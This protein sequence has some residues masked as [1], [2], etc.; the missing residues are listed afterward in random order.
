MR[1]IKKIDLLRIFLRSFYIQASWNYPRLISLGFCYCLMPILRRLYTE[2]V[3]R[4][5]FIKR[6]LDFFNAHPYFASFALGSVARLEEQNRFE[7]WDS[8]KPIGMLKK[9]L[10]SPLGAI[11][12]KL[13]WGTA[14]PLAATVGVFGSLLFGFFGPVMFFVFYNVPHIYLRYYGVMRGYEM[15]FDIVRELSRRRYEKYF[16]V[17][18]LAGVVFVG[19]F[20]GFFSIS[21][22]KSGSWPMVAL[23]LVSMVVTWLFVRSRKSILWPII[24]NIGLLV[25]FRYFVG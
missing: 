11:G 25:G 14:K 3:D 15:G 22:W 23:L 19:V 18:Q 20:F 4:I 7:R 17:F 5:S 10:S 9:R 21:T 16:M 12:D 6:H 8:S 1:A 13:F 24:V 2:R